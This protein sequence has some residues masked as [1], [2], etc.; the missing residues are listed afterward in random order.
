MKTDIR[1]DLQ[2]WYVA[3]LPPVRLHI[4]R[5]VGV[6]LHKTTANQRRRIAMLESKQ[7]AFRKRL[8]GKFSLDPSS[9]LHD[10]TEA[11]KN[12]IILRVIRKTP[13]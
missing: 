10:L 5:N 13:N 8:R 3:A 1:H 11:R 4:S 6:R 12:V 2:K 9:S 7:P